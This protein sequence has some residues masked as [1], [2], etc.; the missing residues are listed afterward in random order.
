M[1][2]R[3]AGGG[4]RGGEW[5]ACS[6]HRAAVS[7]RR[8]EPDDWLGCADTGHRTEQWSRRVTVC[9]VY[10]AITESRKRLS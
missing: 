2:L 6:G 7:P 4:R 10:S 3:G 5:G 8:Q 9:D 1:R